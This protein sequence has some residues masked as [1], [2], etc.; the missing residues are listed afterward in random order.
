M[1]LGCLEEVFGQ[2][3]GQKPPRLVGDREEL[4]EEIA[5]V[6]ALVFRVLAEVGSHVLFEAGGSGVLLLLLGRVHLV[7]GLLEIPAAGD[8]GA[9]EVG[10]LVIEQVLL[11]RLLDFL[12][13]APQEGVEV[14]GLH[15][16]RLNHPA[17]KFVVD[18]VLRGTRMGCQEI[19]DDLG[20]KL[21]ESA[22]IDQA[23][24]DELARLGLAEIEH[25]VPLRR[26][27]RR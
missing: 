11:D 19:T 10:L 25:Q 4:L 23:G 8:V 5:V 6:D 15:L 17:H 27:C 22:S 13:H 20:A 21:D 7:G 26:S 16:A 3:V 14:V 24:D 9:E 1:P 2:P 12:G 18:T